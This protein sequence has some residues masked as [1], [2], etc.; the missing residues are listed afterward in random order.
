M[1]VN[2]NLEKDFGKNIS[3]HI[4]QASEDYFAM[5]EVLII[6]IIKQVIGRLKE[7]VGA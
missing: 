3:E 1:M 4:R 5:R 6:I 7:M 2:I